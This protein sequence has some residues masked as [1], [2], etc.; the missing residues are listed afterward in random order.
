[1]ACR[2][3]YYIICV[4]YCQNSD[5]IS[6]LIRFIT[7][8]G[9]IYKLTALPDCLQRIHSAPKQLY[10]RSATTNAF[11]DLLTRKRVAIVGS[12]RVSGYGQDITTTLASELAAQGVVIISGLAIGVDALAHRAALD[13]K[14]LTL[15]VLPSAVQKVYPTRHWRLAEDIIRQGGV[16]VS[17]YD[18]SQ[19][20]AYKSNFVAR[21]RLVSAL[22]DALVITE[23]AEESGSLHTASFALDQGVPVMAVPGSIHSPTSVGANNLLK[24][25]AAP[26]TC[27]AD[28]LQLIGHSPAANDSIAANRVLGGNEYEQQL[29]NLIESG[30]YE[31]SALLAASG[32]SVSQFNH[33]LTMLEITA[34][35]R[36]LGANQWALS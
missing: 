4:T 25:G 17:E 23:A 8:E 9:M 1:M 12:R 21:N 11:D 35:I 33:H 3:S 5:T 19:D 20:M 32:F 29:I 16:L 2:K 30:I 24:Q 7:G 34:K 14:G 13:A 10:V 36:P 26:V 15:A 6:Q 28:I 18:V 27:T 31:G 22:A